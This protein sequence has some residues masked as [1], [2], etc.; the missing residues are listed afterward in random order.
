[1]MRE[2]GGKV[3]PLRT[4]C[5][6][7]ALAVASALEGGSTEA[8]LPE[9]KRFMQMTNDLDRSRGQD[10]TTGVPD[11]VQALKDNGIPWTDETCYFRNEA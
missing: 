6:D 7:A 1:M 3:E 11:L 2:L 9:L 5:R 8:D 4:D 10:I